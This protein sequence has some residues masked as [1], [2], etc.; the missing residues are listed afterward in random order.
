MILRVR[1]LAVAAVWLAVVL[2]AVPYAAAQSNVVLDDILS[3][4]ELSYQSAAY[5]V[6]VS[7][8]RIDESSSPPEAVRAL[9]QLQW[10]VAGRQA[11]DAVSLGE[12]AHL[13]MQAF[14]FPGGLMYRIVPGPRYAARELAA[15]GIAEGNAMVNMRLSG[16]RAL[17]QLGRA[18]AWAEGERL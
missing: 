8:K 14:E 7:T 17:R 16:E 11:G 3:E 18:L 10:A 9:A 4:D 13:L 1:R 2:A 5:L 6:L 12:W 15:L